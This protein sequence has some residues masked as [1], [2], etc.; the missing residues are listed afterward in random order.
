MSKIFYLNNVLHYRQRVIIK[1]AGINDWGADYQMASDFF[2]NSPIYY[3]PNIK[4]GRA[5]R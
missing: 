2:W 5:I 3:L 4:M 1:G